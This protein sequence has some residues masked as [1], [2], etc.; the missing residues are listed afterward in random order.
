MH[1]TT[2]F[3]ILVPSPHLQDRGIEERRRAI[4][5]FFF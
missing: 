1:A 4:C 3:L 5:I 2:S